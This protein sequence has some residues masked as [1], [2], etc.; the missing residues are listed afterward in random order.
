MYIA[1]LSHLPPRCAS[2]CRAARR[3]IIEQRLDG[4]DLSEQDWDN[5]LLGTEGYSGAYTPCPLN[6]PLPISMYCSK[7]FYG[8]GESKKNV[9]PILIHMNVN[10]Q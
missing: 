6:S 5:I 8:G 7:G 3:E 10:E 1:L 4:G 9:G 2:F